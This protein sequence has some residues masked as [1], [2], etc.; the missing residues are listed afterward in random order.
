MLHIILI[1]IPSKKS[2]K[3]NKMAFQFFQFFYQKNILKKFIK[4]ALKN[5]GF[6]C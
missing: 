4:K 6:F 1:E 2:L 5:E 3:L